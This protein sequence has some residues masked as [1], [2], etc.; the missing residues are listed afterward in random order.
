[1]AQPPWKTSGVAYGLLQRQAAMLAFIDTF[2]VLAI[3]FVAM[4]PLAIFLKPTGPRG[5][6]VV[7]D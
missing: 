2:W 6:H 3:V 4:I 7:M 1:M 5:A